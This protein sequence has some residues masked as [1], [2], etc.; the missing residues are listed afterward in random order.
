M[1]RVYTT[2]DLLH[3][4]IYKVTNLFSSKENS[5]IRFEFV[6]STSLMEY[7]FFLL[8]KKSSATFYE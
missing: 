6:D 1:I 4:I 7:Y 2:I 3:N 5:R 8:I